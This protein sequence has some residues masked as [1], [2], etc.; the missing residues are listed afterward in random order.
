M[1]RSTYIFCRNRCRQI[2][3][4]RCGPNQ[5]RERRPPPTAHRGACW[6][7]GIG[8]GPNFKFFL[9]LFLEACFGGLFLEKARLQEDRIHA[10]REPWSGNQGEDFRETRT[11]PSSPGKETVQ[12][13]TTPTNHATAPVA[14]YERST[15]SWTPKKRVLY[16]PVEIG[17]SG[18]LW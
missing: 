10:K 5:T 18:D 6:L 8:E 17:A 9:I 15:A 13:P 2:L 3:P 4:A 11:N 12:T 16:V 14:N 1:L 7:E